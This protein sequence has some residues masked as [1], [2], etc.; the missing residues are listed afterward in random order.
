[1][2]VS[3]IITNYNYAKYLEESIN[4][5]L[6][7]SYSP[8]EVIVVDDGSVDNSAKIIHGYGDKITSIFKENGGQCSSFNIGFRESRGEVVIFLDADD[9]LLKHTAATHVQNLQDPTVVKSCGYMEVIGANGNPTGNYIP[10]KLRPSGLYREAALQYGLEVYQSSYT[11]GNA[12]AR[13]FLEKVIPLPE[14]DLIGADGYLTSVDI[15]FGPIK[16]IHR[17]VVQYRVHGKN[18]GPYYFKFDVA[19]MQNRL[20][21]RAFRIS[22]AED[23]IKKLGYKADAVKFRKTRN[24]KLALI[25]FILARIDEP[26]DVPP[27]KIELIVSPFRGHCIRSWCCFPV[28]LVLTL[29][30]ILPTKPAMSLTKYVLMR[31]NVR[32][33]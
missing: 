6:S 19:S 4:S 17:T 32:R 27:T 9:I 31:S 33:T 1:M 3:I 29:V 21:R 26:Y 25:S 18:K 23:W 30:V 8:V 10:G 11:S 13:W 2:L 16:S 14:N 15:L 22:Y 24:W 28:S 12:W 20:R 5:A 7:Q